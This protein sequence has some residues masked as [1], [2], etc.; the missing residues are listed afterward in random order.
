MTIK[1]VVFITID[2]LRN[3][4]VSWT[5]EPAVDTPYFEKLAARGTVFEKAFATAPMTSASIPGLLA[6]AYPMDHGYERLESAHVPVQERLSDAGVS[7]IG[8]TGNIVTSSLFDYDR[9]FDRFYDTIPKEKRELVK[10]L[11]DQEIDREQGVEP[12]EWK[13]QRAMQ[14]RDNTDRVVPYGQADELTDEA[15]KS[16]EQL[17]D[18]DRTFMWLHYMDPHY[19]Y[20]PPEEFVE[21]ESGWDRSEVNRAVHHWMNDRPEQA[22][23]RPDS[24]DSYP[25]PPEAVDAFREYYRAEVR[26]VEDQIQ[27]LLSALEREGGLEETVVIL[28]ADH[29]EE[30]LE[31]GDYGHRAKMYDEL[32]HVPLLVVDGSNS[33]FPS[34]A[35]VAELT[36]LVDLPTT[37]ADVLDCEPDP[38]WRGQ[39]LRNAVESDGDRTARPYALSEVCHSNSFCGSLDPEEAIVSLR[40]DSWKYI[41]NRQRDREK[42]YDLE[43]DP[44]EESNEI[45]ESPAPVEALSEQCERRLAAVEGNTSDGGPAVPD[46]AKE[47]L[48]QLGYRTE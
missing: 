29:G 9:G 17:A 32:L 16:V 33:L 30:F 37:I 40:S 6:G 27:R 34:D 14:L 26:F 2:S 46:A 5:E 48:E 22:G 35:R 39:S 24:D 15:L 8:I 11:A 7:T 10:R 45:A 23:P 44:G 38:D 12:A 43:N 21:G 20:A 41:K 25:G 19:P 1:N 47:R 18:S 3:D 31:H 13:R 36:S 4:H 28:A 42:A